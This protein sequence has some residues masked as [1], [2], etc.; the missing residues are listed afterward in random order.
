[1]AIGEHMRYLR[2]EKGYSLKRVETLTGIDGGNLSRYERN[3]NVPNIELCMQL[4]K[5]YGVSLDELVGQDEGYIP[6]LSSQN[7]PT[8]PALADD[9]RQLLEMFERM[10]HQQKIKAVAYCEGLL[11]TAGNSSSWRQ[12]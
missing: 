2:E 11:S 12:S 9:A 5:L 1:M 3:M 7:S 6:H 10:N 4:A 8:V